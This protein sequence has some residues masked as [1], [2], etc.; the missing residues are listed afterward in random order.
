MVP[1]ITLPREGTPQRHN[2]ASWPACRDWSFC[3]VKRH[4]PILTRLCGFSRC[5]TSTTPSLLPPRITIIVGRKCLGV[6]HNRRAY[7]DPHANA[8]S[9]CQAKHSPLFCKETRRGTADVGQGDYT[10]VRETR[11]DWCT[12]T[13]LWSMLNAYRADVRN[14]GPWTSQK[15]QSH[16]TRV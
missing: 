7:F 9:N 14:S 12:V 11:H 10:P 8:K 15:A 3:S 13:I 16:H 4:V 5:R 1:E 2:H 6:R